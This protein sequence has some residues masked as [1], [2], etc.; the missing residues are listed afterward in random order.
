MD[1]KVLELIGT[2]D[3]TLDFVE[4]VKKI[5]DDASYFGSILNDLLNQ[6]AECAIFIC[7]CLQPSF[8]GECCP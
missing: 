7:E 5:E 3:R 2:I 4:D 6:V 1:Q 8:I